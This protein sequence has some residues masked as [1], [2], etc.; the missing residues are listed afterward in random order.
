MILLELFG[1][2]FF[3][4]LVSIGGGLSTIPLLNE[5]LIERGWMTNIEII[6]MI[7]VSEM[8]PGPIGI[9]MATFAGNKLAGIPGG[10]FATLGLVAPSVLI[11]I[12]VAHFYH[13]YRDNIYVNGIMEVIR[14]VVTG[15]IA[16]VCADLAVFSLFNVQAFEAGGGFLSLFRPVPILIAAAV[17][18]ANYKFKVHPVILIVSSAVLGII[19]L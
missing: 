7:A 3:I 1:I 19:L 17:F 16:A 14:P 11:I 4:G 2:F 15:L 6:D 5:I 8:T 13:K 9:N 12:V 10:I 18:V